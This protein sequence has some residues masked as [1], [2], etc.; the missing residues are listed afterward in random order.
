M[1][2]MPL[3]SVQ[4]LAI[5]IRSKDTSIPVVR[6]ISFDLHRGRV[7]AIVG[8]SG[9]GKTLT[10]LSLVNLLPK[11]TFMINGSIR[12]MGQELRG[13]PEREM[14]RIRGTEVAYLPQNPMSAF[15]PML[16]IGQHFTETIK[17]HLPTLNNKNALA[18][19]LQ[20]LHKTG[21]PADRQL[22]EAYSFQLSGGM[23]QRVMLALGLVLTPSVL[24]AD[25]PTSALDDH[26]REKTLKMLLE[27]KEER[28]AALLIVS[29][30]LNE[31]KEIAD[32]VMV[33]QDG[34]MMEKASVN[35][36]FLSPQHPFTKSL[37][38]SGSLP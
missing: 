1:K 4:N 11:Q 32:E 21:L 13:L 38:A 9:S 33:L 2:L 16:T 12:L 3:L 29:H 18:M 20:Y 14:N 30:E 24:I 6:N 31:I 5:Q 37:L 8:G 17:T 26:N 35:E 34:E 22:L 28:N 19:A 27:I 10:C 36:L 23:L 7:L 15:H 25:E